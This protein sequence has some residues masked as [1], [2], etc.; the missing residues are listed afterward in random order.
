MRYKSRTV[1]FQHEYIVDNPYLATHYK[2]HLALVAH[3]VNR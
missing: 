2:L 1:Y 3:N